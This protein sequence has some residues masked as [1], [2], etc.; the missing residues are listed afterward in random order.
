MARDA[1]PRSDAAKLQ[2]GNIGAQADVA[3]RL[4]PLPYRV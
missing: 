1:A 3:C 4:M 2:E